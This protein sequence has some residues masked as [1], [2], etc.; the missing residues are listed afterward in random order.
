MASWRFIRALWF[1]GCD[2][3]SLRLQPHQHALLRALLP[4][5]ITREVPRGDGHGKCGLLVRLCGSNRVFLS[6]EDPRVLHAQVEHLFQDVMVTTMGNLRSKWVGSRLVFP[7]RIVWTLVVV[8]Q[9][10]SFSQTP[11]YLE[12][13]SLLRTYQ[14]RYGILPKLKDSKQLLPGFP[15][16]Y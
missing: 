12:K 15:Y 10:R 1:R 4:L 9:A 11:V 2:D 7:F 13:V 3:C 6:A 14:G 5:Q 8:L 16:Q